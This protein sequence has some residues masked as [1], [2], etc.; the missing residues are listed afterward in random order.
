[1]LVVFA[2]NMTLVANTSTTSTVTTDPVAI[3][4]NN[5]A[6]GITN[7]HVIFNAGAAGL[8][9][10]MQVS[11]DGQNWVDMGPAVSPVITAVGTE[12][13]AA[14][15]VTCVYARLQISFQASGGGI[16]AATFDIHVNFDRA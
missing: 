16:G 1:M 13:Q 11:N 10:K 2:N 14:A 12:L 9:W 15:N 4:D 8:S 5:R 7:T 6:T 3:G